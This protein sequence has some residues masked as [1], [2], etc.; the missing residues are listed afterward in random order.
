LSAVTSPSAPA[1]RYTVPAI[2]LHWTIAVLIFANLYLG[3]RSESLRGLAKFEVLQLHKSI[4]ITVLALSLA[5]LA[6]RLA[7]RPPPYPPTMKRWEAVAAG[8]VHWAFYGLIIGLPLLGWVVVSASPTNIPTLLY[9]TV[10][11]PHLGFV[12]DLPMATRRGVED[13]AAGT[14]AV[15]AFIA[16]ALLAVHIAA[17]LKH[18]FWTRDGVLYRMAP[19]LRFSSKDTA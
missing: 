14:H 17:A 19:F 11:W 10:P 3:L 5:R 16:M 6:W 7:H 2:A 4:G 15:L 13:A 1:S 18:Q 12:H 8:A 9:K